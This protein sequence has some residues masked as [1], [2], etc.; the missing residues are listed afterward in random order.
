MKMEMKPRRNTKRGDETIRNKLDPV[1]LKTAEYFAKKMRSHSLYVAG[2]SMLLMHTSRVEQIGVY[3]IYISYYHDFHRDAG[4]A[5]RMMTYGFIMQDIDDIIVLDMDC[6]NRIFNLFDEDITDKISKK[7]MKS[8]TLNTIQKYKEF[9]AYTGWKKQWILSLLKTA[10]RYEDPLMF[11]KILDRI[12]YDK[13][14]L[15]LQELMDGDISVEYKSI[16]L[17]HMPC[18]DPDLSL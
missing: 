4:K 10:I 18:D 1:L 8:A 2:N 17:R 11:D 12:N 5:L 13:Y 16:I 6:R 3:F 7:E 15:M 9:N 14:K